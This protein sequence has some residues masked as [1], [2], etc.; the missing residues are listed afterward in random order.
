MEPS[1]RKTI[2]HVHEPGDFHE[3]TFSCFQRQPLLVDEEWRKLLATSITRAV[4]THQFRLVAFVFMPE[5]VHLLVFPERNAGTISALLAAI[6]RPFSYRIKQLLAETNPELLSRLTIRQRP[7]AT[8][9][10]Y[11]Q[12]GPGFDRNLV[13]PVALETSVNYIHNN[14]VKRGLCQRAIDWKW[15]SARWFIE[16]GMQVDN[17]LP[18]LRQMPADWSIRCH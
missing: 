6:K 4:T 5:H 13:D 2:K 3:L 1:H 16:P 12:E 9:F 10:R 14:P 15:S 17:D 11:W 8:T 18:L 7:G